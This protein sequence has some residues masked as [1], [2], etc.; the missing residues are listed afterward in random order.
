MPGVA[1]LSAGSRVTLRGALIVLGVLLVVI[2]VASAV[3]DARTD[4]DRTE[5]RARRDFSNL[6]GLLAEQTASALEA[7]DLVLRDIARDGSAAKIAALRSR[8]RD[9]VV[10]IPQVNAFLI[11]DADGRVVQR[12]NEPPSLDTRL[13]ERS[14]FIAHRDGQTK[15]L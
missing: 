10:H 12:S 8:L 7:V 2:N 9:E 14:Y 3:W 13:R 15:G 4:R 11:L 6:T 1:N 5:L